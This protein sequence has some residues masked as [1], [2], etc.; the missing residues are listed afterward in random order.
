MA[1]LEDS[2]VKYIPCVLSLDWD[3]GCL[4]TGT[5]GMGVSLKRRLDTKPG[6]QS[7]RFHA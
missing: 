5:G 3:I 2:G 4:L 6:S 1:S 7:G